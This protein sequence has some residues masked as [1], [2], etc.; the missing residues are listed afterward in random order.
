MGDL[1]QRFQL[2]EGMTLK[3]AVS[4]FGSLLGLLLLSIIL[5]LASDHFLTL[6][7]LM[8]IARQSAINSLISMGML[9]TI[10]TAG[11]DLSVGSILAL[12]TMVM[13]VTT[14]TWGLNPFLGILAGILTGTAL[15][16]LNGLLLTKL[17]LPHPFI[18]TLG[19]KNIARGLALIITGATPISGFPR[20]IQ[21]IG[22]EFIGPVPVS[23]ILVIIM[24]ILFA[25]FLNR[26]AYG[27]H[28]YAVGGNLEAAKLSGINVEKTLVMVY[29]IS[30]T[31]AA[32][33]G[34]VQV[35]RVNAAFP[36][37]G[38]DYDLDAIAAVI[39]GGAS[40]MGGQGTVWGTLIGAM[41]M[42]VLR[43]G[44]NL[45]GVSADL[46]TVA[47]GIVIIGAVYVDVLRR[48]ALKKAK[49]N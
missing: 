33:A 28:I 7:N 47:I 26:T 46:Q 16:L 27:K 15:G 39:I 19:T 8:N 38:L 43:N 34:L 36:L 41:I 22:S 32:I 6:D 21:F 18:S 40:F 49:A 2:N 11:I 42:A 20:S 17:K 29:T 10:L 23:F 5:A 12:S 25:V 45:L 13:G 9:L 14:V 44:L 24:C 1:N 37:A 3:N 4:K 35:G 48:Q 30:G 31:M